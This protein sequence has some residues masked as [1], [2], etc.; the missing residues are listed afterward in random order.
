MFINLFARRATYCGRNSPTFASKRL[1]ADVIVRL[2][3][4]SDLCARSDLCVQCTALRVSNLLRMIKYVFA[5]KQL[6]RSRRLVRTR[7]GFCM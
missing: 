7:Y 6:M 3:R 5:R 2:L 1:I 4:V